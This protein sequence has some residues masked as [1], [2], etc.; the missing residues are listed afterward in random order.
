M[1]SLPATSPLRS[2]GDVDNCIDLYLSGSVDGIITVN[3][4]VESVL[5][6]D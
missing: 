3:E 4:S 5:Q 6:Y 2:A 1:I